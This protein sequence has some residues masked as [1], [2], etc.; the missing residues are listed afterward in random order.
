VTA[1]P[2]W[3]EEP[4]EQQIHELLAGLPPVDPP[5]GFIGRAV[6]H[7]PKYAC[8]LSV[9]ALASVTAVT[10]VIVGLGLV[11]D[12][13]RV[14]PSVPALAT[15]HVQVGAS[16]VP[17]FD[18]GPGSVE[19]AEV[20]ALPRTFR[21]VA[22]LRDGDLVQYVYDRDGQPVSVFVQ[23]GAVSWESLPADGLVEHGDGWVWADTERRVVVL[24]IGA[25]AVAVVGLDVDEALVFLGGEPR[26]EVGA[27]QRLHA[28]VSE[29]ARQA[30]F[31]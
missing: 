31:P 28:L 11:G 21:P 24:E 12:P 2:L 13:E 20:A 26:A 17:G 9:L 16:V 29:V 8:R 4:W 3:P 27:G 25:A 30:G 6:D 1:G 19:V 23:P 18:R 15:R 22:T 5:E 14:A 10:V 7:R